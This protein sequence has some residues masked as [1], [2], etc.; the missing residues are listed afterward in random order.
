[1]GV[2]IMLES[3]MNSSLFL[4]ND[5]NMNKR[6]SVKTSQMLFCLVLEFALDTTNAH[7]ADSGHMQ[8][9]LT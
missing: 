8:F 4:A 3:T 1:M 6:V 9:M 7:A 5:I 2:H